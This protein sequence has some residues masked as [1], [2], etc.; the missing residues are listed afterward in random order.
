MYLVYKMSTLKFYPQL[1]Y[2]RKTSIKVLMEIFNSLPITISVLGMD[3]CP[4]IG[5]HWN[6]IY[7]SSNVTKVFYKCTKTNPHKDK[8]IFLKSSDLYPY[9]PFDEKADT[10]QWTY[11]IQYIEKRQRQELI[12]QWL[13]K[14]TA[15]FIAHCPH[16]HITDSSFKLLK[17]EA[18]A[19]VTF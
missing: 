5:W 4:V 8:R 12:R 14:T 13:W 6:M 7:K 9:T 10:D 1:G 16:R 19:A 15:L 2:D 11:W 3:R 18:R 17:N